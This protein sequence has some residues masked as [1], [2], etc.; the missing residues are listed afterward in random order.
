MTGPRPVRAGILC[1]LGLG[2][3]LGLG[4]APFPG[5]AA[6]AEGGRPQAPPPLPMPPAPDLEMDPAAKGPGPMAINL[7]GIAD[8]STEAPFLDLM[9]TARPWIGH[10][11]REWGGADYAD[12]AVN[13]YLDAEGWPV[14]IPP[15]LSSIGTAILT[16]MPATATGLAGRYRLTYAGDGIVEVGGRATDIRY[17][18]QSVTFSYAPGPGFVDIRIQRT[19]RRGRGDPVR[20]IRVVR[21]DRAPLLDEGRIF[22]PDWLDRLDRFSVLRFADW[23]A[24][25]D[26]VQATW[27]D[28][29]RLG[30]FSYVL[31]G[32]PAELLV[33][34]ADKLGADAWFTMPHAADDTYIRRFAAL[35]HDLSPTD[36]TVWVEFSN[37]VWNPAYAQSAW[38]EAEGQRRWGEAGLG[39]QAYAVR[40][41]EMA[42]I[43]AGVFDGPDR[44]RLKTVISTRTDSPGIEVLVMDPPYWRADHPGETPLGARFDAYAINGFFGQAL[45][46]PEAEPGLSRWLDD[47][48]RKATEAAWDKGLIAKGE[49]EYVARHR[50]DH[51][52]G[53]AAQDI[54]D[55]SVRGDAQG[56]LALLLGQTL[57]YHV[58][59]ARSFDLVPVMYAAGTATVATGDLARNTEITAF[60]EALNY[61]PQM[62]ALYRQLIDGWISLGGTLFNPYGDVARPGPWGS[63]G[64][65]RTLDDDNPRWQALQV[66]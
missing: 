17:G 29:P 32:V 51:A 54:L 62:G 57:P 31:R 27:D 22:N 1:A 34:L 42:E 19:D 44:A 26:S 53:V 61:S 5:T 50:F 2:L 49:D 41:A 28:R 58:Q 47:S 66:R 13:G 43:W 4:A 15:G 8:W 12:L 63:W 30:D 38:A 10:R 24:T 21:E 64:H 36:M 45:G 55:G 65:L 6:S 33:A 60:L 52:I 18:P 48:R 16:D 59:V 14:S 39:L 7:M 9:K 40:A 25:D 37:E 56:T 20:N 11:P 35:V 3:G 46:R 23:M